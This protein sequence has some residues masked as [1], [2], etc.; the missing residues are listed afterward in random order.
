[1]SLAG[2]HH[3]VSPASHG[4]PAANTLGEVVD[5]QDPAWIHALREITGPFESISD[6]ARALFE[7]V[8]FDAR[9]MMASGRWNPGDP[10]PVSYLPGDVPAIRSIVCTT[11]FIDVPRF[12]SWITAGT[13]PGNAA[14]AERMMR[15]AA[16]EIFGVYGAQPFYFPADLVLGVAESVPPPP[17]LV[18]ELRLPFPSVLVLFGHDLD[19]PKSMVWSERDAVH[20]R[21]VSSPEH[22]AHLFSSP[23]ASHDILGAVH[24]R[25]GALSGIVLF[26]GPSGVGLA[27]HVLWLVTAAPDLDGP[28]LYRSDK[29][30]GCFLGLRSRS[31]LSPVIDNFAAAVAGAAWRAVRDEAPTIGKVGSDRWFR[32]LDRDRA[33]RSIRAGAFSGVRVIDLE[34]SRRAGRAGEDGG[35]DIRARPAEHLRRGHTRRVRVVSR[36]ATGRLI[37]SQSGERGVDWEYEVRWVPPVVVNSGLGGGREVQ[38]W[39]LPHPDAL[40]DVPPGSAT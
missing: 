6:R 36:D 16:L 39:R 28:V 13:F 23:G 17:P 21:P 14:G 26:A 29:Q 40:A 2:A 25:G 31:L 11:S 15:F 9:L 30:R 7:R 37:G 18:A 12:Q 27:D 38:V 20:L 33:R 35:D 24:L 5:P 4:G 22:P 1:M 32:S 8:S 19:L 10:D 34:A 3:H